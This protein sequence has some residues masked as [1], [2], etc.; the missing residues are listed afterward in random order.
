MS[1][2]TVLYCGTDHSEW[3]KCIDFYDNEFDI[4]EK[5]L[6]ELVQKNNGKE[7]MSW[8]EHFQNQF[9]VQRNN[10]D[11]LRHR[12]H[13]HAAKVSSDVQQHAGKIESTLAVEH[14]EMNEQFGIF[15]KIV[16]DLRHEFNLFLSKKM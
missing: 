1:Y 4:L 10:I 9:V 6:L 14:D 2:T 7:T 11:E 16:N 5:R 12:I 13:E 8:V 3:L 15:E